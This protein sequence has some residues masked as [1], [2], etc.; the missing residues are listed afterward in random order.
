MHLPCPCLHGCT[1]HMVIRC[2]H[3][4]LAALTVLVCVILHILLVV[5][6]DIN[7]VQH[8]YILGECGLHYKHKVS[9]GIHFYVCMSIQA[10]QALRF[11][12]PSPEEQNST[13]CFS[14]RQELLEVK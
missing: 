8:A 13:V 7:L 12:F 10:Q 14:F 6:R 5:H 3:F 11:S 1:Y 2:A 4:V 9:P